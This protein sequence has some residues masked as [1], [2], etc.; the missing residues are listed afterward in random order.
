MSRVGQV[1]VHA[2]GAWVTRLVTLPAE[3]DDG[4]VEIVVPGVTPLADPASVRASL[5]GS[6]RRVISV[7]TALA[8][9]EVAVEPGESAARVRDLPRQLEQC[10]AERDRLAAE[11]QALAELEPDPRL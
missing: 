5:R 2:R 4:D 1:T 6:P 3:L 7:T 9:P 10:E 8:V 11:R